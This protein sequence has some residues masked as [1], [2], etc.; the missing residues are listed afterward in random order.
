MS[1]PPP[2]HFD[3]ETQASNA[4][5]ENVFSK[6]TAE[7]PHFKA[8]LRRRATSC[9]ELRRLLGVVER[10]MAA[11]ADKTAEFN[12]LLNAFPLRLQ[13]FGAL[14]SFDFPPFLMRIVKLAFD[15]MHASN[16]CFEKYMR[17]AVSQ[18]KSA[19]FEA[20]S[21]ECDEISA[22]R[23]AFDR[24]EEKYDAFFAKFSA[25]APSSK[26]SSRDDEALRDEH[27]SLLALRV[28]AFETQFALWR[29]LQTHRS[30]TPSVWV[31]Q[32]VAAAERYAAYAAQNNAVRD[33]VGALAADLRS[34]LPFV[35]E[36][37]EVA[38]EGVCSLAHA[39]SRNFLTRPEALSC[40]PAQVMFVRLG[41]G[42]KTWKKAFV[43][44]E[45]NVLTVALIGGGGS[46]GGSHAKASIPEDQPPVVKSHAIPVLLAEAR[47]LPSGGDRRFC[48]EIVT[49]QQTFGFQAESQPLLHRWLELIDASK[50]SLLEGGGGSV[51]SAAAGVCA[52]FAPG[53]VLFPLAAGARVHF[54]AVDGEE[55]SEVLALFVLFVQK[56]TL[57]AGTCYVSR[58]RVLFHPNAAV[59]C[60]ASAANS[61]SIDFLRVRDVRRLRSTLFDCVVVQTTDDDSDDQRILF[62]FF[63]GDAARFCGVLR[64]LQQNAHCSDPLLSSTA[65]LQ[66]RIGEICAADCS[67]GFLADASFASASSPNCGESAMAA[68]SCGCNTHLDTT[69]LDILINFSVDDVFEAAFGEGSNFLDVF[70]A[71]RR[72]FDICIAPWSVIRAAANAEGS[73]KHRTVSYRCPLK[74]SFAREVACFEDVTV[75]VAECGVRYVVHVT[76]R[77]SDAPYA[78]YF[79]TVTRYCLTRQSSRGCCRLHVCYAVEFVKWTALKPIIVKQ[80]K[81]NIKEV[82]EVYAK[83]LHKMLNGRTQSA[84]CAQIDAHSN[85]SLF[86]A[87]NSVEAAK[88]SLETTLFGA[89]KRFHRRSQALAF[90]S[91]F[92]VCIVAFLARDSLGGGWMNGTPKGDDFRL[93]VKLAHQ[94]QSI[95]TIGHLNVDSGVCRR[96]AQHSS[97]PQPLQQLKRSLANIVHRRQQ[98]AH[99]LTK[100][101]ALEKKTALAL[102]ELVDIFP[103]DN[104]QQEDAPAQK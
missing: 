33:A 86:G 80:A 47:Q 103:N 77:A 26:A 31:A 8:E 85:V 71:A 76:A 43:R 49:P 18:V 61:L 55:A 14:T 24:A 75:Q 29:L 48:F 81:D 10:E 6:I 13:Q 89:K 53:A 78:D 54:C 9:D 39:F 2:L 3:N 25:A 95:F 68:A 84:D 28:H 96:D 67:T 65:E 20:I 46:G 51:Q 27:R 22:L 42:S 60:W 36:E 93:L 23:K 70:L 52:K 87:F 34:K 50:R 73:V 90:I 101:I 97:E 82:F 1:P 5:C 66:R 58:H 7:S 19:L 83:T 56:E 64:F 69:A 4:F 12:A 74:S 11:I 98:I 32:I 100:V 79:E 91:A 45:T 99:E 92:F 104:R 40:P 62:K 21:R 38:I 59:D 94:S 88:S 37:A 57:V 44:L 41:S 30:R 63:N 102:F 16:C 72:C 35:R 17:D 15:S